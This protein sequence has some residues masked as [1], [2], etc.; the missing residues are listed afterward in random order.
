MK[1]NIFC[2]WCKSNWSHQ[3]TCAISCTVRFDHR[4]VWTD[5]SWS[6]HRL[7]EYIYTRYIYTGI[8]FK[9]QFESSFWAKVEECQYLHKIIQRIQVIYTTL[10]YEHYTIPSF[11]PCDCTQGAQELSCIGYHRSF[12][13]FFS[14][15]YTIFAGVTSFV[16]VYISHG[17]H[18][19][20]WEV[21]NISSKGWTQDVG[22]SGNSTIFNNCD[23]IVD[24]WACV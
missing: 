13:C 24:D 15:S 22:G 8:L 16:S 7:Q 23:L 17:S 3:S 14:F 11:L 1:R 2:I 12:C 9:K 20:D 5:G 10:H 4:P 19:S 21:L 6:D 18:R